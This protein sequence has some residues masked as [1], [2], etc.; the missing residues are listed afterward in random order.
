MEDFSLTEQIAQE[1]T[2]QP[3]QNLKKGRTLEEKMGRIK[4]TGVLLN[5][6]LDKIEQLRKELEDRERKIWEKLKEIETKQNLILQGFRGYGIL[7][8]SP[9]VLE[10]I[11]VKD[12]VDLE[13]LHRVWQ[14]GAPGVLPKHVASDPS[15][16]KYGLKHYHVSRRIARM[17]SRLFGEYAE[18]LFEKRGHRWAFTDFGFEIWGKTGEEVETDG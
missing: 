11:A 5:R 4:W 14:A 1:S 8:Y 9:S 13:I 16:V 12:A 17:N 3:V 7:K 2:L 18:C 15:L 10:R 6:A